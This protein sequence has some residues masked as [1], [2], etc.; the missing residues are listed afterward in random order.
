MISYIQH[1]WI[2]ISF[3]MTNLVSVGHTKVFFFS[4]FSWGITMLSNQLAHTSTNGLKH[5]ISH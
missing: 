1:I 3:I 4:I 2:G 5:A